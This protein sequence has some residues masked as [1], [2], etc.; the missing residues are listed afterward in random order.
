MAGRPGHSH[1][2]G[3]DDVIKILRDNLPNMLSEVEPKTVNSFHS[4]A[5]VDGGPL[6]H[7]HSLGNTSEQASPG[8]H[9]HDGENSKKI[10][11]PQ[12]VTGANT[13]QKMDSL[14]TILRANGIVS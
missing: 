8:H 11:S 12:P 13:D 14:L 2:L 4:Y 6:A 1:S 3:P 10:F 9:T 7:H 5:D